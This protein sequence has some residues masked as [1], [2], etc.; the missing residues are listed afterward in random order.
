MFLN[1]VI[2]AIELCGESGFRKAKIHEWMNKI[3][4]A[5]ENVL[6]YT[7]GDETNYFPSYLAEIFGK[8]EL[9]TLFK[10]YFANAEKENLYHAQ[11]LFKYIIRNLK[12]ENDVEIALGS[13]AIDESSFTELKTLSSNNPG[14]KKSIAKTE[15]YLGEVFFQKESRATDN[16]SGISPNYQIEF[17]FTRRTAAKN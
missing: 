15:N 5:V 8:Y 14:A 11:D 9:S 4:P 6:D 10:N 17:N 7:D 3:S 2:E 12:Y 1:G 13:T 16:I